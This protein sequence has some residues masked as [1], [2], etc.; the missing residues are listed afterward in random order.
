MISIWDAIVQDHD[1]PLAGWH[2]PATLTGVTVLLALLCDVLR[3]VRL[4]VSASRAISAENL[5]RRRQLT[6]YIE[7]GAKPH[8]LE[9]AVAPE[10]PVGP[11]GYSS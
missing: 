4:M 3:W 10:V 1:D 8:R 5:F 6:L 2:D 7:R 9:V 11:T